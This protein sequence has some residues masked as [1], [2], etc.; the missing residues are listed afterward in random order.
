MG[1]V[2]SADHT[3][4]HVV[5]NK[6]DE[7]NREVFDPVAGVNGLQEQVKVVPVLC[8]NEDGHTPHDQDRHTPL[9]PDEHASLDQ[10][11]HAPSDQN[12]HAPVVDGEEEEPRARVNS[13]TV[14]RIPEWKGHELVSII[15]KSLEQRDVP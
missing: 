9:D 6:Q 5:L 11:G 1:V 14:L 8:H 13:G 3:P 10:D 4:V 15:F 7:A 2:S 12:G